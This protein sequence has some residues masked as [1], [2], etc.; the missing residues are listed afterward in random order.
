MKPLHH[1]APRHTGFTLVELLVVIAILGVLAALIFMVSG[2]MRN[3]AYKV[4]EMA[5]MRT[6]SSAVITYHIDAQVLPG[7]TAIRR[8]VPVPS[9]VDSGSRNNWMSTYLIDKGYLHENDDTFITFFTLPMEEQGVTYILNGLNYTNP[10]HF[11]GYYSGVLANRHPK[12]MSS[13]RSNR[14]VATGGVDDMSFSD[15]WM[16]RTADTE[17]YDNQTYTFPIPAGGYSQWGGRFYVFFDGRIEFF[18]RR[19]PSIY[20]DTR[21]RFANR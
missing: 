5:N 8:G 11:F 18:E 13:L 17:G 14:S 21:E 9:K 7:H 1:S 4:R 12:S 15:I 2:S 16:M 6:V 3:S 10:P 19:T 20:P